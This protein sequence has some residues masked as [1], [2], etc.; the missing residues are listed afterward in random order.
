MPF[1]GRTLWKR[2][3]LLNFWKNRFYLLVNYNNRITLIQFLYTEKEVKG[4]NLIY[5]FSFLMLQSFHFFLSFPT[6]EL[7]CNY[8]MTKLFSI[9]DVVIYM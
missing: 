6:C 3:T 1:I 9:L 5:N 4:G 2:E 7:P 8:K